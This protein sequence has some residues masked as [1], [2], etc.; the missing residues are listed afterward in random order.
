M[1]RQRPYKQS[2][3]QNCA[4]TKVSHL[5]SGDLILFCFFDVR[6]CEAFR[7]YPFP[8]LVLAAFRL[9]LSAPLSSPTAKRDQEEKHSLSKVRF[10]GIRNVLYF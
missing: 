7:L 8:V 6:G 3:L 5:K 1:K 10:S 9:L 2:C 4:N